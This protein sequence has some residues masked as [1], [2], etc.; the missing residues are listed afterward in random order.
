MASCA[1]LQ[2]LDDI[3]IFRV[4][5]GS[6]FFC[7]VNAV[8]DDTSAADARRISRA[9]ATPSPPKDVAAASAS[10]TGAAGAAGDADSDDEIGDAAREAMMQ[11]TTSA[12]EAAAL[13]D[14]MKP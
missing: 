12:M 11:R 2:T 13:S 1:Q 9:L 14:Q 5:K 7:M 3:V 8:V 10:A 4:S 6:D